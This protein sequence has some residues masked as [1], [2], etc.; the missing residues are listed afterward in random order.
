[1]AS[2]PQQVPGYELI[3]EL[4]VGGMATVYLAVQH[5]LDR[6]VAIKVMKRDAAGGT[7]SDF[8]KR[9]LFEGRTMA[10]LPH[11]NIVAV[12]DIVTRAD[13]A[14]IAM[15]YLSDGPLTDRMRRGLELGE[16]ITIAV[17]LANA[18]EYA[19][20]QNVVHRDLKPS[21]VLFRDASTP[22]LTDFG[23][24]K[25]AGAAAVRI[26]QTGMVLGTP[27]YMSPEQANGQEVD[28]RS[29]QYSLGILFYE[30]LTGNAPFT[31]E[32]PMAVLMAHA[33]KPPPPL[34][35]EL[36]VFQPIFDRMLAKRPEDRYADLREFEQALRGLILS[37]EDLGTRLRAG[38]TRSSS[39]QLRQLGFGSDTHSSSGITRD[40]NYRR[41][42]STMLRTLTQPRELWRVLRTGRGIA[43]AALVAGVILLGVLLWSGF[44]GSG[45]APENEDYVR[46]LLN[47][48]Q[49]HIAAGALLQPPGK[50]AFEDLQKVL[51]Q[52]ADNPRAAELLAGVAVSLR[53]QALQALTDGDETRANELINQALLVLPG[54]KE[55]EQVAARIA[56]AKQEGERERQ[57]TELLDK[58]AR[59]AAEPGQQADAVFAL[60]ASARA[61]DPDNPTVA[62]RIAQLTKRQ[63]DRAREAFRADRLADAARIM[64]GLRP[65]FGTDPAFD[66]L[67]F[68]IE[69]AEAQAL[70]AD[71]AAEL[72]ARAR[73][74]LEADRISEPAGDNALDL[75]EQARELDP[76][77]AAVTA[78]ADVL[79][80]RALRNG[81]EAQANGEF[82]RALGFAE[83][84]LRIDPQLEGAKD[85][86][87]VTQEELGA[88]RAAFASRLNLARQSIMSGNLFPPG[89]DNAKTVLEGLIESDPTSTLARE[90]LAG[91][92]ESARTAATADL[93]RGDLDN[94]DALVRS[95]L[96]NYPGDAALTGL[97]SRIASARTARAAETAMQEREERIASLLGRRPLS[98]KNVA[99]IAADLQ[100]LQGSGR[101]TTD[102]RKQLVDAL[103]ADVKDASSVAAIDATVAA[104]RAA[105]TSFGE[106]PALA[107]VEQDASRRRDVLSRQQQA[108]LA[109]QQGELV[110]NALP[111]GNVEEVLNAAREPVALPK[112]RSTPLHLNLPAGS[113]YVTVRHP[114]VGKS[115]SVF[116]RV[117]A[118]DRS[119]A[120]ASFPTLTADAYLRHANL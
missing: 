37:D 95:A 44:G 89:K 15:E 68:A 65:S 52:D 115:V 47:E 28:G 17:Q 77:A 30:M 86:L 5:S 58:A 80:E 42:A 91:L 71:Q 36:A 43:A 109:A 113:Y 40:M 56:N 118:R 33:L 84:A 93:E 69:D 38:S 21:N 1:M 62:A 27:T 90:L 45:G 108:A 9:F 7:V 82:E 98:D 48:A 34:P 18:L 10:K 112:D 119:Q 120:V 4:G 57:V 11:R 92:A 3:R 75:F 25:Q 105:R 13:I 49:E 59:T 8:E 60:L 26:T 94:A 104:A 54:N 61:I 32:T 22:V 74:A 2:F 99:A 114:E 97:A 96:E 85:L 101:D 66:P 19:H 63:F 103:A 14:Y 31:D 53:S 35:A 110:I 24:A 78:F 73:T 111:W 41:D 81:N 76:G 79:A 12:Y 87:A 23:I 100:A 39:S 102:L 72:L 64:E 6:E 107:A 106:L 51:Q 50:N 117:K 20:R 46:L 88:K 70:R 55:S 116:A 16:A 29:D 83:M 67:A